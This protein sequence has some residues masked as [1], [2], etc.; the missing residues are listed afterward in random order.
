[1]K[2]IGGKDILTVLCA[3]P[4]PARYSTE[5]QG[6]FIKRDRAAGLTEVSSQRKEEPAGTLCL[7]KG[8]RENRKPN[9][10]IAFG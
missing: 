1:M 10:M 8:K 4:L 2:V 3:T 5:E 9:G 6:P 7:R